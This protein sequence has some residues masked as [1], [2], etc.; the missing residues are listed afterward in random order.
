MIGHQNELVDARTMLNFPA[1]DPV[2]LQ[3]GPIAV[4]WYGLTYLAAF[5]LFVL[6]GRQRLLHEPFRSV[7]GHAAWTRKDVEDILFFGILGVIVGGRLGYTLFYKPGHYASHPWEIFFLWQG[8]MSFHGGMLGVIVSQWWFARTRGRPFWQV[9]DFIAPC[10]PLGLASGRLGNFINGELWGRAA[11]PSLPWAMVFPQSG[12]SIARHPSQ[13]YQLLLE[14]LLLFIVLWL[15]ARRERRAGEVSALFLLGY[16]SLRFVAEYF[17][18]PDGH[19][20]ILWLELSMG[21][22]LSLPMILSGALLWSWAHW[23][24]AARPVVSQ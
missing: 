4:H 16:G 11:D 17:R 15:Y 23:R 9:M 22:W 8:G 6:L 3:V 21:Q 10:V 19:L 7:R 18:E 13:I 20:G 12:S 2:A 14:G 5:A 24:V 1:I